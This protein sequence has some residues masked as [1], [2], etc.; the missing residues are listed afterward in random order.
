MKSRSFTVDGKPVN[1]HL[2]IEDGGFEYLVSYGGIIVKKQGGHV[3]AL[4]KDWNYSKTT[5]KYR[6]IYLGEST[7]ETQAKVNSGEYFVDKNL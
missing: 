4:G 7:R 5:S 2:I 1:N 3:V 6:S